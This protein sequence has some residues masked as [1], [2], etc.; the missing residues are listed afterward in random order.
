MMMTKTFAKALLLFSALIL[1]FNSCKKFEDDDRRYLKTP[2]GRVA[3]KWELYKITNRS[4]RDYAD[5]VIYYKITDNNFAENPDQSFTYKGMLLEFDRS[6]NKLCL[7][8]G[9]RG[10]LNILNKP[11]SYGYYEIK[12]KRTAFK[13]DV[14]PH[15]NTPTRYFMDDYTIFKMT[16]DEL[17]FGRDKARVYFK[18]AE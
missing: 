6:T 9:I 18:V 5:S 10:S 14:R 15:A 11:F 2:C 7:E 8:T 17:I 13:F 16:S 4:G 3:K 12:F 1:L